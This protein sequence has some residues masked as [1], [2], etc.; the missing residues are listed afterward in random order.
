MISCKYGH[1]TA[2]NGGS[3]SRQKAVTYVTVYLVSYTTKLWPYIRLEATK[4]GKI[5]GDNNCVMIDAENVSEPFDFNSEMRWPAAG[6]GSVSI[7]GSSVNT[8]AWC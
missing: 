4:S 7:Y 3:K 1:P 6:E 8:V 2:E 5:Y